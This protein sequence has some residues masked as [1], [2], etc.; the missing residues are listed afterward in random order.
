MESK[1]KEDGYWQDVAQD[2]K[3]PLASLCTGGG[4]GSYSTTS[5]SS[6][7]CDLMPPQSLL[8]PQSEEHNTPGQ[9]RRPK[10]R[11]KRNY[12]IVS[13]SVEEK[14][15]LYYWYH[16][17]KYSEWGRSGV[18][19]RLCE[20]LQATQLPE[21]KKKLSSAK[22]S[23]IIS[24]IPVYIKESDL[25]EIRREATRDAALEFNS[26]K[27]EEE[28]KRLRKEWSKEEKI[29]LIWATEYAKL[30]CSK[31]TE[32]AKEWRRIFYTLC[33]YK[34]GMDRSVLT[35]QK[36]NFIRS[37]H[38]T[39][40]EI[41]EIKVKVKKLVES[42]KDPIENPI[43]IDVK[44]RRKT[45]SL[46]EPT[47]VQSDV[48]ETNET[49]DIQDITP[50]PE[51]SKKKKRS[52]KIKAPVTSTP[53]KNKSKEPE[54]E[55][56]SREVKE[57][58]PTP[59]P[60]EIIPTDIPEIVV[61]KPVE[62]VEETARSIEIQIQNESKEAG[63]ENPPDH[64]SEEQS[65]QEPPTSDDRQEVNINEGEEE[66]DGDTELLEIEQELCNMIESVKHM[67]M[68]DRPYLMK[69][70]KSKKVKQLT[71]KVNKIIKK[72]IPTSLNI[73]EINEINY[74]AALYIESQTQENQVKR[75]KAKK[76]GKSKK[77]E[78]PKWKAEL[79]GK[80]KSSRKEYMQITQ[81]LKNTRGRGKLKKEI[82]K[83]KRKYNISEEQLQ[84]KS[85][86]LQGEIPALAR[87]IKNRQKR[88]DQKVHNKQFV[89]NR[90]QFYKSLIESKIEVKNP[91]EKETLENFWRPMFEE[92]VKH[93]ERNDWKESVKKTLEDKPEMDAV[94]ITSEMLSKKLMQF[95]NFKAPGVDRIPNFWLKQITSL[96]EHYSIC[97]NRLIAGE[98][99]EPKW[100]T[101]GMTTLI[102]KTQETHLP[103]KYRPICCL[104]TTYKLLTGLI[105]DDIYDHLEKNLFLEN[106]QTGCRRKCLGT[107]DQLLI[108]KSILEDCRRRHKNLSMAWIDY[109]KAY[110]S[111]PHS[112]IL[113]CL[114]LYKIH[115]SIR[116]LMTRQM[117]NWNTSIKLS[118]ENG[119]ILISDVEINKGIFQ[120]DSLSPLIFCL[121]ID[122]L[123]KILNEAVN[124]QKGYSLNQEG[125]KKEQEKRI[126]HLLF[127]DDLKLYAENDKELRH[128][129][130]IVEDYS[131]DIGMSFG[132]DKCA[133]C[134]IKK[135]KKTTTENM[136]LEEYEIQ[137]LEEDAV[138]KYLGIEENDNILH[139]QIKTKVRAE[140]IRRLKKIVKTGLS[141]K[142]KIT[143][144]NQL[145]VAVLS[146]GFG[147]V[148][149][150]QSELN[151]IDVKTRKILTLHKVIYRNQCLP[152]IYLS[153]EKGGLGLTEINQLHRANTVAIAQ[154]LQSSRKKEIKLVKDQQL[155]QETERTS[156]IKQ[157]KLFSK[158]AV[159]EE[160]EDDAKPAT[161]IARKA[162]KTY[163][164]EWQKVVEEEWS[165]HKRAGKFQEELNKEYIDKKQSLEWL[166]KGVLTYDAEKI[167]VAAQDQG[168]MTKGFMKMANLSSDDKCRFC[169]IKVESVSHLLSACKIL[170]AEEY[171]TKRHNKL[172]SYIHWKICKEYQLPAADKVWE[173]QPEDIC[174]NRDVTVYYDKILP[175]AR[176]I[177]NS[178]VKPDITIW[179]KTKR[180]A[181]L[182]EISVPSDYGLNSAERVKK[183]K[184]L[185]L[186]E[187][188]KDSWRLRKIE[189]IP[190]IVGATGLVKKNLQQYLES[191][192]GRPEVLELQT[193]ALLGS[194]TILKRTLAQS[195]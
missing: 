104:S 181:L 170:L 6:D 144:I 126:N 179:N 72:I 95:A 192:P 193:A 139:K 10:E 135:G 111:V 176:Y 15:T 84:Q 175:T 32:G 93:N 12:T 36:S 69:I 115:P 132:V 22:L 59:L 28:P 55:T 4:E 21:E 195:L 146:Y 168:L 157:A 92:K 127:M 46:N 17:A 105:A 42:G 128:L 112:W 47:T 5:T 100:F 182:I 80:I 133:K 150:N 177:E 119:E 77:E 140:Y 29:T 89:T 44:D 81:Y 68:E 49:V 76:K 131:K 178:A 114:E 103:N 19:N 37:K 26:K 183:T 90:K 102:P 67:K 71:E 14:K 191:I 82:E 138:Y 74:A 149:W 184:Y 117:K 30:K 122:P 167:I 53:K 136:Q 2:K 99:E 57:K 98:E 96:H 64:N 78:V 174:G 66:E 116:N 121:T 33:P 9:Q 109:K 39:E 86:E 16:F 11:S 169:K 171:Y 52:R 164:K 188:L 54:K 142:N 60:V 153:R 24:Q 65:N 161:Y 79:L 85:L 58:E 173:H 123:S 137:D 108:N 145:A 31:Q 38:V 40:E 147:I 91:P 125:R 151:S 75:K 61:T 106:Q 41:A 34:N 23:S 18:L 158:D 159:K 152:R 45:N 50:I 154:Y 51:I 20:R 160:T 27:T 194:K 134:T 130:Q 73:T 156:C 155:R 13:W 101:T 56:D 113:E 190:V 87:D 163:T 97:F 3:V 7:S 118:H 172:C 120:G 185:P 180:E 166:R 124:K 148:N 94:K 186:C 110:D 187:D 48:E 162:R 35:T 83:I 143:A 107:K 189:V 63:S 70:R 129:L 141:S 43:K 165:N 88:I 25:E 8:T 62:D 1:H